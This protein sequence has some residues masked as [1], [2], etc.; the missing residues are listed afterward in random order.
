METATKAADPAEGA[1]EPAHRIEPIDP[2]RDMNAKATTIWLV[3]LALG[4]FLSLWLLAELFFF[5]LQGEVKKKVELL[6]PSERQM[7]RTQEDR[8]LQGIDKT[9]QRYLGK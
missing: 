7:M 9:I 8:D 3:S 1:V 2:E 5:V 4:L 6:P